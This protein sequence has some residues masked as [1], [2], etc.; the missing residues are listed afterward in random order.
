MEKSQT[1]RLDR[2]E[3]GTRAR[4]R[5]MKMSLISR[6]GYGVMI[7]LLIFS[8]L[9][10]YKIQSALSRE[11]LE[12]YRDYVRKDEI[13][14]Q[15]RQCVWQGSVYARDFFLS[16]NADRA[17][18]LKSQVKDLREQSLTQIN[19]LKVPGRSTEDVRA[20]LMEFWATLDQA[21][22]SM[23]GV[24]GLAAHAFLQKEIV[25]RRSEANAALRELSRA[26]QG[27]VERSET[28]FARRR[29]DAGRE[30]LVMLAFSLT[31]GLAVAG[32]SIWRT[33]DLERELVLNY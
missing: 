11:N 7:A 5:R 30:I 23:V 4:S 33:G 25:P 15:L 31:L 16:P 6:A 8:I 17:P 24:G 2:D 22:E 26:S 20:T 27:A 32:F 19:L 13:L 14:F 28:E 12:I 3:T 9:D 18:L 21:A 29:G 10:A 1:Q